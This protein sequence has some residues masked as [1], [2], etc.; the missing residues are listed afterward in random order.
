MK[1]M[2]LAAGKGTR[3]RPLTHVMPKPMIPLIRKPIMEAIV[4]HLRTHG[5]D[6]IYVNTSYLSQSIEDYFRDGDRFGVRMAFSYE[7]ELSNGEFIDKPVGSA[8][9][10]RRIQDRCGF[11]DGTFAVLCGDA[12]IDVDLG[13]VVKFHQQSG[14]M[15]T[16]VTKTV[17]WEEVHRYGVVVSDESGRVQR[18]QEKPKRAEAASNTINT[19]IYLFEPSVF[20]HIPAEG[21]YDIGSQLFPKLIASGVHVAAISLPFQ[22]VDIGCVSDFWTATRMVL[23][24]EV[25]G[26]NLPGQEIA[27]GVRVG[28]GVHLADGVSCVKGPVYIGAGTTVGPG[29]KIE[30]PTVIGANCVIEAGAHVRESILWDYTR[31]VEG[32]FVDERIVVAQR[33]VEPNGDSIDLREADLGWLLRDARSTGA[34]VGAEELVQSVRDSVAV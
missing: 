19:G 26:F 25:E 3:V 8:G 14:A 10:M 22:W 32:S 9:G 13:A 15:A 5:F 21:E 27:P 4:D 20:D 31:V 29:A 28:L 1:A 34:D 12:L 17:P 23:R 6:E 33:F 30:G 18:F 7:G 2:I 16:I 24:G 11:F